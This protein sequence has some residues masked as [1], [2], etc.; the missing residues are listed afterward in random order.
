[1]GTVETSLSLAVDLRDGVAGGRPTGSPS[2]SLA[3]RPEAFTRTPSGYD[4]LTDLP[5]DV[6]E[7]TVVVDGGDAHLSERRTVDLDDDRSTPE[8]IELLPSPAYPFGGG[9][10]VV[11]GIVYD[12]REAP[13]AGATVTIR[14]RDEVT[15]TTPAGEYALWIRSIGSD[16]VSD[17]DALQVGGD[18]PTLEATH[19]ET[20]A[21][22]T[23]ETVIGVG[24]T[25]RLDLEF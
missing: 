18:T 3:D 16:D 14:D 24:E 23:A 9:A 8:T 15:R 13:V 21:T 12:E 10:T 2:V 7:V 20:G 5:A 22:T 11:R 1:M 17:A 19:P 4:V 6:G 25:T